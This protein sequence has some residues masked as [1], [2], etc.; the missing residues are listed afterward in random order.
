MKQTSHRVVEKEFGVPIPGEILDSS[1]WTQT[2]LKK[3]P[4]EGKLDWQTL[5][6]RVAP[7]VLDLGCGNG[8]YLLGS[9]LSRP[10]HDHLGIDTLPVVIRYARRRGNQRGLANLKFAVGGATHLLEEF[11]VPGSVAEIHCYHPQPYYDPELVHKRLITPEFLAIV[12]RS[13]AA[14]GLFVFQTDNPGYWRYIKAVAPVFF[15]FSEQHGPWPDAPR[16]RTRREIIA[17]R[18]GLPVYRGLGRARIGLGETE[19]L[20][21]A[22]KLP[23]PVFDADRRFREADLL[24]HG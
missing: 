11:V 12:H 13:L 20:A 22:G 10:T 7:V 4:P 1:K 14:G 18:K 8:R 15:E 16:G 19:A 21:L 3:M 2:A 17:L 5:F 24:D 23:P 6:G 9:A